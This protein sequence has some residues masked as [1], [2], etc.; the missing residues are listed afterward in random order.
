MSVVQ[1]EMFDPAVSVVPFDTPE[2]A[3][4]IA[5]DSA[6]GLSGASPALPFGGYKMRL[7]DVDA[8]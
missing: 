2:E 7:L 4:R 1:N 8:A 5:N 6:Y 3:V